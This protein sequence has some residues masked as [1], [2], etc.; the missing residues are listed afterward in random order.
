M[1]LAGFEN[2]IILLSLLAVPVMFYL[3]SKVLT[4]KKKAAIQFSNLSYI[5]SCNWRQ[6]K[7]KT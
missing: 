2:E 4:K 7:N 3:Y 1:K 6:E 5:K